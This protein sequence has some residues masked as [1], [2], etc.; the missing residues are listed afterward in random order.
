MDIPLLR[1]L[2]AGVGNLEWRMGGGRMSLRGMLC[3]L[4]GVFIGHFIAAFGI[5]WQADED[6]TIP[7]VG[8][9]V[10][11]TVWVLVYTLVPAE[12]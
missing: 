4:V 5:T 3:F 2:P 7:A 11:V 10:S 12:W 6:V 1:R 8:L 9:V